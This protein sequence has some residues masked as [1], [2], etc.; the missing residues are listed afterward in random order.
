[1][2]CARVPTTAGQVYGVDEELVLP[3][4]GAAEMGDTLYVVVA[5]STAVHT[6]AFAKTSGGLQVCGHSLTN[7]VPAVGIGVYTVCL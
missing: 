3:G 5:R 4:P 7:R 2:S 6:P 1:M